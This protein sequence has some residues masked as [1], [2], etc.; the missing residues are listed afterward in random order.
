LGLNFGAEHRVRTGSSTGKYG[1]DRTASTFLQAELETL[2]V[3]TMP[4]AEVPTISEEQMRAKVTVLWREVEK[5]DGDKARLAL[6]RIFD[7]IRVEPLDG[8][9]QA[10]W[11]LKMKAHPWAVF[12]PKGEPG[13]L[14]I[15]GCGGRI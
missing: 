7:E 10:G 13:S 15:V 14:R 1:S 8:N 9:W 2:D 12:A 4:P 11:K 5:L 3:E 6:Q